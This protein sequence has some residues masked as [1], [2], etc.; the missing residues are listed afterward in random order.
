MAT[1]AVLALAGGYFDI[2]YCLYGYLRGE[3]TYRARPSSYWN[4]RIEEYDQ[5]RH[6]SWLWDNYL[7]RW[8]GDFPEPMKPAILVPDRKAIPVLIEIAS[9]T[10]AN[11]NRAAWIL[12]DIDARDP[13]AAIDL[14]D[15]L[16]QKQPGVRVYAALALYK[17]DQHDEQA[18]RALKEAF[19]EKTWP[20]WSDALR[21]LPGTP[22]AGAA[23]F[24]YVVKHPDVDIRLNGV[25]CMCKVVR[26]AP[27]DRLVRLIR[28]A[29]CDADDE[30]RI[31]AVETLRAIR[32][33]PLVGD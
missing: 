2:H 32:P 13:D 4:Q 16:R 29:S 6:Q 26:P 25:A 8:F 24:A 19:D 1:V 3:A 15:C 5:P 23:V 28:L 22:D 14:Q 7:C 33:P 10:S 31:L 11:R 12:A 21:F 9:S 30:V 18:T 27:N 17:A 20:Y